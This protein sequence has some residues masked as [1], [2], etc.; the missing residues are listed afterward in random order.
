MPTSSSQTSDKFAPEEALEVFHA[1]ADAARPL[2]ADDIKD[3]LGWSRRTVHNK[4]NILVAQGEVRTR[5]VGARGRVWW[6]PIVDQDSTSIDTESES[7]P[8]TEGPAPPDE[9]RATATA[10]AVTTPTTAE[11]VFHELRREIPG[12]GREEKKQR[13]EAILTAYEYLQQQ[14]TAHIDEIQEHTYAAHPHESSA[15]RQWDNYLRQG[16][17]ALPGVKAPPT[18]TSGIW[19]FVEPG[20]DLDELLQTDLDDEVA[21]LELTERG[22]DP[23]GRRALIQLAYDY[24]RKRGR[25]EKDEFEWVLPSDYTGHYKDFT[26]LWAR[27]L[28]DTLAEL[29][30]VVQPQRGTG[31]WNYIEPG[32]EL[33]RLLSIDI[34]PWIKEIDVPGG[35]NADHLRALLQHAY[36]YLKTHGEAEKSD[37]REALP[38]YTAHYADFE[39]LWSYWLRDQ[40]KDAQEVDTI[41]RSARGLK[42]RY[43]ENKK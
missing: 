42:F 28:R 26:G 4:L 35:E 11:E 7:T 18:P 6:I 12:R 23:Q 14:G 22:Q 29:P 5:K 27:C 3:A 40:L 41:S 38:D 34:D 8:P 20:S 32:S 9:E 43:G 30:G 36:N 19:H 10:A 39:G 1:R 16:L 37:F 13:A 31:M 33:D 15:E 17:A 25:V 2:T 24:L 21:E